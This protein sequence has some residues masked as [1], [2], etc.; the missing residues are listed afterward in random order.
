[1][2]LIDQFAHRGVGHQF[3]YGR[4]NDND[5]KNMEELSAKNAAIRPCRCRGSRLDA[6]AVE[7][8]RLKELWKGRP[9]GRPLL[10]KEL[11]PVGSNAPARSGKPEN[12]P[13]GR[14][15]F[16]PDPFA[17]DTDARELPRPGAIGGGACVHGSKIVVVEGCGALG[18]Q[19]VKAPRKDVELHF[20]GEVPVQRKQGQR[21]ALAMSS[22]SRGE[23][24]LRSR[25]SP[26]AD[27]KG[28]LLRPAVTTNPSPAPF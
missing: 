10:R 21:A 19:T 15:E 14:R 4:L 18:P 7:I 9:S 17:I 8:S 6:A 22:S 5:I 1:M 20:L 28:S 13:G 12:V 24:N 16:C 11:K 27:S 2:A 25:P 26:A 23:S 3:R